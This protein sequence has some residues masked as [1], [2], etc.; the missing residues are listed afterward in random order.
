MAGPRFSK[1]TH[2][3][4]ALVVEYDSNVSYSLSY[5]DMHQF[6]RQVE[7]WMQN[8]LLTAPDSMKGG[9]FISDLAF[10]D[11]QH[12]LSEGTVSAIALAMAIALVVLVCATGNLW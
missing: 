6:Y 12:S 10:Y 8:Q 9:W 4:Q 3:I 7:E 1:T 11:V 2:Q 5:A